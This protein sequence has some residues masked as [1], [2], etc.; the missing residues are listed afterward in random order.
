MKA[1]GDAVD[2]VN[3]GLSVVERIRRFVVAAQPFTIDNEQMT[4]TMKIRRHVIAEKY[5]AMLDALYE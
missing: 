1:L 4:P 2:D 5:G 3:R